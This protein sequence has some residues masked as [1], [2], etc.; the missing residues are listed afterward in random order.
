MKTRWS[1]KLVGFFVGALLLR[2]EPPLGALLGLLIGH[3]V[4]AGWFEARREDPYREL[5]VDADASDADIDRAYRRL[6]AR[7]HPDRHAT[8]AP[9][10]QREAEKRARA[11][12]AAYDRIRALR[13]GR[14]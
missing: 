14:G 1:G 13:S 3:A 7:H 4:D 9:R 6:M 12:N 8:A 11:I 5:G 2:A 10:V